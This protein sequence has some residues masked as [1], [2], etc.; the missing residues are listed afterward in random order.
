MRRLRDEDEKNIEFNCGDWS[1][2]IQERHQW[3]VR[4]GWAGGL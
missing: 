3:M 2:S 1:C 4:V